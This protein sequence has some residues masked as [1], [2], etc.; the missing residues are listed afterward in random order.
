MVKPHGLPK[1]LENM[2]LF[3]GDNHVSTNEHWDAFM[4]F[5]RN[6]GIGHLD[7]IYKNFAFTLKKDSRKW[8]I[9]LSNNDII[10]LDACK[11]IFFG[12]WLEKRDNRFF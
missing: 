11:Y 3:H 12:R 7:V 8:C 1:S 9:G 5:A 10:S 4:D 6:L 2:P